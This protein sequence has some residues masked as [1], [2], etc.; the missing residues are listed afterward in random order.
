MCEIKVN[1][2]NNEWHQR[3]CS[4]AFIV[5]FEQIFCIDLLAGI[6]G[7]LKFCIRHASVYYP[8]GIKP[9]KC[10]ISAIYWKVFHKKK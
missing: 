4:G 7:I 3:R 8:K 1:N 6:S 5:T 10:V 2:G 9:L